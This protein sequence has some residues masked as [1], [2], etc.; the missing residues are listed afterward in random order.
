MNKMLVEGK[1][2]CEHGYK[3]A[4]CCNCQNQIKLFKHPMNGSSPIDNLKFGAGSIT[5][6]CGW[7]CMNPEIGEGKSGI[8]FDHEHGMCECWEKRK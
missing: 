7:V 4:C 1:D 2:S 5:D 8:Y 6:Q 3:G